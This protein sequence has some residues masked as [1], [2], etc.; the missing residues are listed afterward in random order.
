MNE[1]MTNIPNPD[2]ESIARKL[3]EVA[4]QT[5][6][7]SQFAA[8]LEEKL[9]SAHQPKAGWFSRF[10]PALPWV[11]V[12]VISGS[13]IELEHQVTCP[14]TPAFRPWNA[15]HCRSCHPNHPHLSRCAPDQHGHAC[16]AAG[17]L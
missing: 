9:R 8:A 5:H 3:T 12:I 4:E 13:D 11:V 7:N 15:R 16:G 17:W 1:K 10:S 6:I 2:D 14:G